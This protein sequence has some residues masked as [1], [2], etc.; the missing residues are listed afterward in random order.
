MARTMHTLER[1]DRIKY[2]VVILNE[3]VSSSIISHMP[4][5]ERLETLV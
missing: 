2:L 3:T 5:Y 1:K 4:V